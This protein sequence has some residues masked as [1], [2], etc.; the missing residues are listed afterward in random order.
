MVRIGL[1]RMNYKVD[2]GLYALGSPDEKSPVV[3]SANYKLSFDRL[4]EALPGRNAWILVLDT[5]G[6]NVWCAA[7]KGSFGTSE[8]VARLQDS[9][10]AK[11]IAHNRI[12]VPQLGASGISAHEVLKLSGFKV[13]YGPVRAS[14]LPRFID[15]GYKATPGM[16]TKDFPLADR[17]ALVPVEVFQA[18]RTMLMILPFLF[19]LG[20]LSS[21]DGFVAGALRFGLADTAGILAGITG[22]CILAPLLL[23][24]LPG[25][26]FAVKGIVTGAAM[27]GLFPFLRITAFSVSA[28]V[29]ESVA[30]I[31]LITTISSYLAMKFTGCSTFTSLSGVKKEMRWAVPFQLSATALGIVLLAIARFT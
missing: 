17:L 21:R 23:P 24:W 28:G 4:R 30:W 6:V 5:D 8:L 29:M 11:V 20:G 1:A 12:I 13:T 2:P 26:A 31:L 18:A 15:S 10:V 14:D 27:A 19:I 7:G 25:R 3:I 16:R 22:G 9:G